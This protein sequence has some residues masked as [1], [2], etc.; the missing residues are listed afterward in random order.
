MRRVGSCHW[1]IAR[2][3][4]E[5]IAAPRY[6]TGCN[7]YLLSAKKRVHNLIQTTERIMDSDE[8]RER[9]ATKD[10]ICCLP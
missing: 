4:I 7:N 8:N 5:A 1:G 2:P 3:A 10:R 6:S 9:P